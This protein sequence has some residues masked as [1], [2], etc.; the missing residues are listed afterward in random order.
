LVPNYA[1]V[2]P[3]VLEGTKVDFKL[4]R[5]FFIAMR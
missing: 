5:D 1:P 3:V 4:K 2:M